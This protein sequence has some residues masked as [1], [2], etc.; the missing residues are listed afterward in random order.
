MPKKPG[1]AKGLARAKTRP[2]G[3]KAK[4]RPSR[5]KDADLPKN[6]KL[7]KGKYTL[8][9]TT[10]VK[11]HSAPVIP[12]ESQLQQPS[13]P[14]DPYQS[15]RPWPSRAMIRKTQYHRDIVSIGAC[16]IAAGM[17]A[18]PA[19]IEDFDDQDAVKRI[20]TMSIFIAREIDQSV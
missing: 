10:W 16:K 4:G 2:A 18:N 11:E 17:L 7:E 15:P 6:A 5:P 14:E 19:L 20:I 12:A 8:K 1:K 3:K 9:G 13:V